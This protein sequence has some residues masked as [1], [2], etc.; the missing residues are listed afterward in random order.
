MNDEPTHELPK[1]KAPSDTLLHLPPSQ[2]SA[3]GPV[4]KAGEPVRD[5]EDQ[6]KPGKP[7]M[8]PAVPEET[9]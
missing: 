3:Q 4:P 9:R 6:W 8:P 2:Q 5:E 1:H 7:V